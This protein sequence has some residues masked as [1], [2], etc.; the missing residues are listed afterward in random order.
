MPA[1][2]IDGTSGLLWPARGV[3]NVSAPARIVCHFS[4]GAA[5]AVATALALRQYGHEATVIYNVFLREEH[6][7]NRRFAADCE[8][9]F[10]HPITVLHNPKYGDSAREVWRAERYL[11]GPFGASCSLRLKR[12]RI[13]A[14]ARPGDLNVLGFTAEEA[15]RAERW[16]GGAIFPLVERNLSKADCLAIIERAG[17]ELPLMYRMG[18]NNANCIGCCK[19]GAG[20][21]NKIRRDFPE[22]FAEVAAIEAEIGPGAYIFHDRSTPTG[23]R[24]PLTQL[25]PDMGRH[26]ELLPDCSFFCAMAEEELA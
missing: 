7:D 9:W 12:E 22:H 14:Q 18:Y 23:P 20:Y 24:Y 2:R 19:G 15:E 1:G 4:C 6:P 8:K 17:I 25:D 26:D 5:S 16:G 13:A 10:D 3:L 21:W 11:K